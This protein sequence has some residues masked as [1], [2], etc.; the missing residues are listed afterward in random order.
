MKSVKELQLPDE[1]NIFRIMPFG[2]QWCSGQD[3]QVIWINKIKFFAGMPND[4][5]KISTAYYKWL[6]LNNKFYWA[7]E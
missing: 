4:Y 1:E 6:Y 3:S 5:M 2:C 7:L